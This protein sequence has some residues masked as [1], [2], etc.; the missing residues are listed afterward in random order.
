M[1]V[2][3]MI[4]MYTREVIVQRCIYYNVYKMMVNILSIWGILHGTLQNIPM[5]K[6]KASRKQI[7]PVSS[8]SR[9]AKND[10]CEPV[11]PER[12]FGAMSHRYAAPRKDERV[13]QKKSEYFKRIRKNV[14][15]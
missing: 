11:W 6:N 13:N 4:D 15:Q 14:D 7:E 3:E 8:S 1:Y 12:M 10:V 2:I 9:K 5:Q